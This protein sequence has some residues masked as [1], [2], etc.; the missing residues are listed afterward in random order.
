MVI[1]IIAA[2][3]KTNSIGKNGHLLHRIKKDMDRFRKLTTGNNAH[4]N[5][6]LMGKNTFLELD[7]SLDKRINVVLTSNKKFKA[8]KDVIVESSFD[9]VLNHYLHSG[10][11]DKDL[12]ICGGEKL[13]EQALPF[14]DKVYITYIHDNKKGDRYF[15]YE[16]VKQQFKI[17]HKEEHEE[18]GLKFEFID[19]VRKDDFNGENEK[20]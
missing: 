1:N 20:F 13:F 8:P 14:S 5:I 4:P 19:Y 16:Q 9:K 18:N 3:N 2:I 15:P 17:I 6:C 7:K 10:S 12:W 11:Q